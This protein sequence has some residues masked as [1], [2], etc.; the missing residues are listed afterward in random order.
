MNFLEAWGY[1]EYIAGNSNSNKTSLCNLG[2]T[3][4]NPDYLVGSEKAK[5]ILAGSY[6]FEAT[7]N[8]VYT[9]VN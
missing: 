9:K 8:E 3:Y 4:K 1:L 2:N 6:R 5:N 7:E